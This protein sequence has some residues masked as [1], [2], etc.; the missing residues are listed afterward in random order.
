M[1][2]RTRTPSSGHPRL[3]HPFSSG[4]PS[5]TLS[6]PLSYPLPMPGPW[7][8]VGY[9][10]HPTLQYPGLFQAPPPSLHL[11]TGV[12][13]TPIPTLAYIGARPLSN[14]CRPP[15]VPYYSSWVQGWQPY[16]LHPSPLRPPLTAWRV[17]GTQGFG[18]PALPP[19]A[20][21]PP[22]TPRTWS[23]SPGYYSLGTSRPL[24]TVPTRLW[25]R[26]GT[27]TPLTP[28]GPGS[29]G[30]IRSALSWHA[31]ESSFLRL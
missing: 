21:T 22:L 6:N 1:A 4:I 29:D 3:T 5:T 16:A 30:L 17:M 2:P 23:K 26:F 8:A 9:H 15:P 10:R 18:S 24:L 31:C 20:F 14:L 19:S 25:S 12:S 27:R 7:P 13:S 28:I 11:G